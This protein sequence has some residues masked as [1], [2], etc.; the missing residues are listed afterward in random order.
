MSSRSVHNDNLIIVLTE[1][2]HACLCDLDWVSLLLISVEWALDLGSVHLQLSESAGTESVRADDTHFPSLLHV[3]IRK[4]GASGRLT[5]T[6]Q[7][8]K[9]DNVRLAALELVRLVAAGE[10]GGELVN[11]RFL[12]N[13]THLSG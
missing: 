10:H 2:G 1:V 8:D 11:H 9:H 5:G 13:S 3:V 7:A 6:L 4:L 12:N